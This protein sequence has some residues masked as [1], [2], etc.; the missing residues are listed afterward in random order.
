MPPVSGAVPG[1]LPAFAER[2]TATAHPPKKLEQ[3]RAKA[4]RARGY[5]LDTERAC[6]MWMRQFILH[7]DKRHPGEMSDEDVQG[8]LS[9]R[10]RGVA[11]LI[12]MA[13][14]ANWCR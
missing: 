5:S 6:W 11:D 2:V 14:G 8:F 7:F 3:R 4:V 1:I 12:A 13:N 10:L 9:H